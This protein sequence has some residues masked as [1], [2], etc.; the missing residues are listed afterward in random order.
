LD[1]PNAKDVRPCVTQSE[2]DPQPQ[3]PHPRRPRTAKQLD[4]L[5]GGEQ[6][7]DLLPGLLERLRFIPAKRSHFLQR[8]NDH[9]T[10][11]AA[12]ECTA[13]CSHGRVISNCHFRN[14]GT[15]YNRK[16]GIK[17]LSCTEK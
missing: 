7:S 14:T 3:M 15:E 6:C 9:G 8:P 5:G 17:W 11:F 12:A 16:P 10:V 4:V 13:R 1:G 2:V